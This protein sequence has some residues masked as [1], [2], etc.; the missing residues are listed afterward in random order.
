MRM[1]PHMA[2]G[3][4]PT[5]IKGANVGKGVVRRVGQLARPYRW[6]LIGF[7]AVIMPMATAS[8]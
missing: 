6:M 3:A 4:D 1:G 7:V 2:M 8:P 5:D